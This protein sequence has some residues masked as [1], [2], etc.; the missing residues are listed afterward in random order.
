[1]NTIPYHFRE[2]S[3]LYREQWG[4]AKVCKERLVAD[5]SGDSGWSC[6]AEPDLSDQTALLQHR[7]NEQ[8]KERDGGGG[9]AGNNQEKDQVGCVC[10]VISL[11]KTEALTLH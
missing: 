2:G 11:Y 3:E 10:T 5:Y 8:E 4:W 7:M 6:T 1:M 9:K